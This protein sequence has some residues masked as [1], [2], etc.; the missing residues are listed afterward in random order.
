MRLNLSVVAS[1][2]SRELDFSNVSAELSF[3]LLDAIRTVYKEDFIEHYPTHPFIT[4]FAPKLDRSY[5]PAQEAID[6]D[7]EEYGY[8]DI[9]TEKRSDLARCLYLHN[10]PVVSLSKRLAMIREACMPPTLAKLPTCFYYI[11]KTLR[12]YPDAPELQSVTKE[13]L[14]TS[15]VSGNFKFEDTPPALAYLLLDAMRSTFGEYMNNSVRWNRIRFWFGMPD[16]Y[17]GDET[18]LTNCRKT[19]DEDIIEKWQWVAACRFKKN[20]PVV[21]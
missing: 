18:L 2:L 21:M 11:I 20:G 16:S 12:E 6:A 4:S 15:L 14:N 13:M 10:N 3:I 5:R 1:Y 8:E 9:M 17:R 7:C 19:T